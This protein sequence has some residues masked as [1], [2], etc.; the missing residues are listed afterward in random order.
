MAAFKQINERIEHMGQNPSWD[1]SILG[2]QEFPIFVGHI[3]RINCSI[4][5]ITQDY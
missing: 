2:G 1:D 3:E 4:L 5:H